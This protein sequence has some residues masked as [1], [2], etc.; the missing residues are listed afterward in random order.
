MES[1][2]W[3]QQSSTTASKL[4][5]SSAVGWQWQVA[6]YWHI[7]NSMKLACGMSSNAVRHWQSS[8]NGKAAGLWPTTIFFWI[9]TGFELTL[10][11]I[12]Y[13]PGVNKAANAKNTRSWTNTRVCQNELAIYVAD[14]DTLPHAQGF[15]SW[16]LCFVQHCHFYPCY[17]YNT[18]CLNTLT[19]QSPDSAIYVPHLCTSIYV[20][21]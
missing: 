19:W 16:M 6:W 7:S 20:D 1:I 14:C 11:S 3:E 18:G 10:I 15:E 12:D 13:T 21:A 9:Q 8:M 17:W 4:Y 5:E 2:V